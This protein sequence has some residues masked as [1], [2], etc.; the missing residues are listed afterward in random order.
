MA[1]SK[2]WPEPEKVYREWH[3]NRAKNDFAL[4]RIQIIQVEPYIYVA[5]MI[6][7]RGTKVGSNGVP[8]RYEAIE[9]CL[10]KLA[11]EAKALNA[12]VHM[13]RIGCGLASGKWDKIEPLVIKTLSENDVEVYVYNFD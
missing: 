4:G 2:R 3:R 12:S 13:P 1:I 8:V 11:T 7:Q 6:G 10:E 5:N 9:S